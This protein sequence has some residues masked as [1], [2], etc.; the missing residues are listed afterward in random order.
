MSIRSEDFKIDQ[1]DATSFG[2]FISKLT[3]ET[4][5][6]LLNGDLQEI[7]ETNIQRIRSAQECPIKVEIEQ[8]EMDNINST[9]KARGVPVGNFPYYFT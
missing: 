7:F 1:Y 3:S 6:M 8:S 9:G 5:S 2:K 4:K